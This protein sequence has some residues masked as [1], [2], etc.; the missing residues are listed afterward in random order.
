MTNIQQLPRGDLSVGQLAA[1]TRC[2][3]DDQGAFC[4]T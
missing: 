1:L 3:G 2:S 4:L